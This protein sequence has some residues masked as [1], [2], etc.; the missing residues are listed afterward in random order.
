MPRCP[1]DQG[2][3]LRTLD[4]PGSYESL[5]HRRVK[6]AAFGFSNFTHYRIRSLLDAGKPNWDLLA[7]HTPLRSEAPDS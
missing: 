1:P 3:N 2:I 5:A 6:R 4:H 7:I